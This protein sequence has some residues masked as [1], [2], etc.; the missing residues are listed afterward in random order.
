ML[1]FTLDERTVSISP[2]EIVI[3]GLTGR[4]Q[5]AVEAHLAELAAAGVPA[6]SRAPVFFGV[7]VD[8]ATQSPSIDVSSGHTSGEVEVVLLRTR[9]E[10]LL[11]TIGSDHTDRE[12]EKLDIAASKQLCPKPLGRRVWR[13]EDVEPHWDSLRLTSNVD[14]GAPYQDGSMEE[15][16]ALGDLMRIVDDL[17]RPAGDQLIF[18]GTLP[19]VSGELRFASHFSGSIIDPVLKRRMDLSYAVRALSPLD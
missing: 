16:M 13:Y 9:S 17:E 4:D 5:A 10:G 14:D 6:P 1:E 18:C 15:L 12:L 7:T 8:R 3:A 2:P 19:T 11:V